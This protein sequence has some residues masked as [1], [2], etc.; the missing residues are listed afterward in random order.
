MSEENK[1]EIIE[2]LKEMIKLELDVCDPEVTPYVCS[3]NTPE[4]YKNLEKSILDRVLNSEDTT[5]AGAIEDIER[6]FNPNRIND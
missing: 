1:S 4:N 6:E 2:E 3:V 5:I